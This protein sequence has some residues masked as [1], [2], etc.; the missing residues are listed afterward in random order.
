M[1]E[2][3]FSEPLLAEMERLD[4]ERQT[5][6]ALRVERTMLFDKGQQHCPKRG[7]HDWLP[8][9]SAFGSRRSIAPI[10]A[11]DD[12]FFCLE[13]GA[14]RQS[15]I[16]VGGPGGSGSVQV[17]VWGS[18]GGGGSGAGVAGRG[19]AGRAGGSVGGGNGGSGGG[20]IVSNVF[21]G[22][23]RVTPEEFERLLKDKLG[24]RT[25]RND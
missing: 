8:V 19:G 24:V 15:N 2:D 20:I 25:N 12:Q 21:S 10:C 22:G 18:G 23:M 5:E 14:L 4:E 16:D 17:S 9:A 11:L 6:K 1:I 13:C 7:A 3:S